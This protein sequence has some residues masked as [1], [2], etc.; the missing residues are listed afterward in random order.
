MQAY[1]EAA[2]PVNPS[3]I[4]S[5]T[6]EPLGYPSKKAICRDSEIRMHCTVVIEGP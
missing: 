4:R 2:L 1:A 5:H 3:L 6:E